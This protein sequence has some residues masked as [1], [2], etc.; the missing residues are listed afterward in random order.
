MTK[1][2]IV[3]AGVGLGAVAVGFAFGLG[4]VFRVRRSKAVITIMRGP[5]GRCTADTQPDPLPGYRWKHTTWRMQESDPQNPCLPAAAEVELRFENDDSP[6][7]LN[8]RPRHKTEIKA[9]VSPFARV[10]KDESYVP[11]RYKV[12]AVGGGTD[13]VMEDPDLEIV[14]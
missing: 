14:F 11:Y 10:K 2:A 9:R 13:Y 1:K 6:F 8:R 5:D 3:A 12:W 7:I 4:N